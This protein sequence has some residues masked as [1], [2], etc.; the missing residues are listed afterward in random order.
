[1]AKGHHADDVAA[2][3]NWG[4]SRKNNN[5]MALCIGNT[6]VTCAAGLLKSVQWKEFFHTT[7]FNIVYYPNPRRHK[8]GLIL[9]VDVWVCEY[10]YTFIWMPVFEIN[11]FDGSTNIRCYRFWSFP[12]SIFTLTKIWNPYENKNNLQQLV[13]CF[14]LQSGKAFLSA[15]YVSMRGLVGEPTRGGFF[16]ALWIEENIRNLYYYQFFLEIVDRLR[17]LLILELRSLEIGEN[18]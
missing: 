18:M 10:M 15:R 2:C 1:M 14:F 16:S 17:Y 9:T 7:G 3:A 8:K 11:M 5:K 13:P 4:D 6:Y 12:P